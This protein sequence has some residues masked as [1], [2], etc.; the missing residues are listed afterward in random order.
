MGFSQADWEE[1]QRLQGKLGRIRFGPRT[2]R[3]EPI[4]LSFLPK[5]KRE[6]RKPRDDDPGYERFQLR[7]W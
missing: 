2:Q 4:Q 3:P 6:V 5:L 1:L 7:L